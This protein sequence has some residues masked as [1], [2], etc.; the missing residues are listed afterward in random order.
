MTHCSFWLLSECVRKKVPTPP[1][2]PPKKTAAP[3]RSGYRH[4]H[5]WTYI[6]YTLQKAQSSLYEVLQERVIMIK[7]SKNFKHKAFRHSFNSMGDTFITEW[8]RTAMQTVFVAGCTGSGCLIDGP[9]GLITSPL[10]HWAG[11]AHHHLVKPRT[12]GIYHVTQYV[13]FRPS[14][15]LTV[16]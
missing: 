3:T 8:S 12:E 13:I 9:S 10:I 4:S 6:T 16:Q 2:P 11:Q 5:P 14:Q 7:F 15:V 1:P